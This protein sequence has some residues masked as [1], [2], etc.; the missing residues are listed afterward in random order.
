M[1]GMRQPQPPAPT[2]PGGQVSGTVPAPGSRH[3]FLKHI[4]GLQVRLQRLGGSSQEA[5]SSD[6][7]PFLCPWHTAQQEGGGQVFA[8]RPGSA[9]APGLRDPPLPT[10]QRPLTAVPCPAA[11]PLTQT[12]AL[13]C[14]RPLC[15]Q[16]TLTRKACSSREDTENLP[17]PLPPHPERARCP[18]GTVRTGPALRRCQAPSPCLAGPHVTDEDTKVQRKE[19][20]VF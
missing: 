5:G 7:L 14:C 8:A 12:H 20:L 11:S 4:L 15:S 2:A 10:F 3:P 17:A 16:K 18:R 6:D 19:G 13:G 1:T 9:H